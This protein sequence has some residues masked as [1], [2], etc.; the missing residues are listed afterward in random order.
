[1][2]LQSAK[3][4]TIDFAAE[5]AFNVAPASGTSERL[6]F[7]PSPGLTL[8][9]ATIKSNEQRADALSSMGRNGSETVDG[10]YSGEM[11][12][13]SHMTLY[14]AAF[15]GTWTNTLVVTEATNAI[16]AITITGSDT[17]TAAGDWADTDLKVGDLFRIT[18]SSHSANVN[19]NLRIKSLVGGV[20]VVFGTPLTDQVSEAT[21]VI[22]R[23]KKLINPT[24]GPTKRT[25]T[26]EQR[27]V[28]VDGS[29]LFSGCRV[30]GVKINGTPD[31][32]ATVEFAIIGAGMATVLGSDSPYF[33]AGVRYYTVPL[34]FADAKVSVNGV[35]IKIATALEINYSI[36]A[37]GQPVIGGKT[38]PDVF[39]NDASV[40][41][42]FT[43]IRKDFANVMSFINEDEFA[44]NVL[45]T[46]PGSEPKRGIAINVPRCKFTDAS[47]PLG[48]DGAMLESLPFQTGASEATSYHDATLISMYQF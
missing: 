43:M 20:M 2:P 13:D 39:D 42:S 6:R 24:A 17:I 30:V 22:T 38:T 10:S 16:G 35:D 46:Q 14:Q 9:S 27:Y 45:L 1:M 8:K 15:R 4:V 3:N 36:N 32:S 25:L 41:G 48:G 5:S 37:A 23:G 7:T 47:A 12:C 18:T 28:D 29:Q 34:V 44:L 31:G 21:W 11:S 19:I 40:S 33:T 26:F